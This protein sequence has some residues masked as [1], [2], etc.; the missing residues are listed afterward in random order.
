MHNKG[1][2]RQ[3]GREREE[4][5]VGDRDIR[6]VEGWGMGWDT[7]NKMDTAGTSRSLLD[8]DFKVFTWQGLSGRKAGNL[9]DVGLGWI[10][11]DRKD[12]GFGRGTIWDGGEQ[13]FW[14]PGG[15]SGIEESVWV[16][17]KGGEKEEWKSEGEQRFLILVVL[18]EG[19]LLADLECPNY[20]FR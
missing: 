5:N 10:N 8:R 16:C 18:P 20:I 4:Q 14:R 17:S 12:R 11:G 1:S 19:R 3:E 9:K 13:L 7:W 15:K 2:R 6:S